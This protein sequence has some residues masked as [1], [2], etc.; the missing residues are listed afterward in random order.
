MS[1][2]PAR[3]AV[4]TFSFDHHVLVQTLYTSDRPARCAVL[5]FSFD[6]YWLAT[7]IGQLIYGCSTKVLDGQPSNVV[8][9]ES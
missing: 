9:S 6:R 3:C 2:R 7:S 1:D 4:L 8:L 5:T